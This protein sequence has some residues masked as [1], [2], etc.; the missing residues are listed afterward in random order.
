MTSKE[1]RVAWLFITMA[2]LGRVKLFMDC[3]PTQGYDFY[4]HFDYLV[5]SSEGRFPAAGRLWQS[6]QP[7]CYY[8]TAGLLAN[9]FSLSLLNAGMMVSLFSS[10]VIALPT[11]YVA[12]KV[13]PGW[14]WLT[15]L[16]L[17]VIPSSLETSSMIYGQQLAALWIS[18]FLLLLYREWW[19][20][21]TLIG[22]VSLGL[23]WS[24]AL[25]T[26][27]DGLM[28]GLPVTVMALCRWRRSKEVGPRLNA[29]LAWLL[30]CAMAAASAAFI[31]FRNLAGYNTLILTNRHPQL[32]PYSHFEMLGLP[33]FTSWTALINPGVHLWTDPAN[34]QVESLPVYLYQQFCAYHWG[35]PLPLQVKYFLLIGIGVLLARGATDWPRKQLW[36]PAFWLALS[37]IL[38][39]SLFLVNQPDTTNYKFAYYHATY[40]LLALTV[41][42]GA[43]LLG[44]GSL[45]HVSTAL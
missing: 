22:T 2:V 45:K 9:F 23:F 24:L 28:L 31:L 10:V 8:A 38:L 25:L 3:D 39:M 13:V 21:P 7:P 20:S 33:G 4:S 40:F 43:C 15:V 32:F 5:M 11:Y 6:Y 12:R 18:L 35:Y 14:E 16:I 17:L 30:T 34:G 1:K 44:K 29:F 42:K 19:V 37:N 26:R 27:M 41:S 36:H